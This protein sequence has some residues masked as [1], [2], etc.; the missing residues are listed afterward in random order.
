[1]GIKDE[2]NKAWDNVLSPFFE[3]LSTEVLV[4]SV[5][6]AST[7]TDPLYDEPSSKKV[8]TDP[9]PVRA[10]VKLE[11]ERLV[12]GG[13]EAVEIDGRVTVRTDELEA[14]GLALDVGARVTFQ[15][16]R[17]T[18]VHREARAEVAEKFLLTRVA[19]R[20]EE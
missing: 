1:M 20:K 16:E 17:Y 2:V 12:L 9:V 18:V 7:Q 6:A 10:R 3:E 11:K 14:K 5:D 4:Q 15:G 13:G 19:V 8:F